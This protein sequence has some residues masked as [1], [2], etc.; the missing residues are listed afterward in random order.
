M[1]G[2]NNINAPQ[3]YR[4][5][6]WIPD[7]FVLL[8]GLGWGTNYICMVQHSF[9]DKTY[10]MAIIPLCCN[11][12]WEMVYVFIYPST[13][14]LEHVV[15]IFGLAINAAV[16]YSAIKFSP[17]EWGHARLVQENLFWIFVVGVLACLSGHL[18]LAAEIGPQLAYSWGAVVCQLLLSVGGLGQLLVRGSTRGGSYVAWSVTC[19]SD[20]L[21][22]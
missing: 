1:D 12:S 15:F 18:A 3:A 8:M 13:S 7:L 9:R 2:F 16:M 14:L 20:V 19:D 5:I 22:T 17:Q 4:D 6:K 11:I 21:G 10:S